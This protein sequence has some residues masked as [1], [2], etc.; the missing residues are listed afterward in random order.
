VNE[1]MRE[2]KWLISDDEIGTA[3]KCIS[4]MPTIAAI[5]FWLEWVEE[6]VAGGLD[7]TGLFGQVASGLA[8]LV[9]HAQLDSFADVTRN[10]GYLYLGG[11]DAQ[12]MEIHGQYP[13]SAVADQ[14][15]DRLYAIEAAESPPK[16]MS[17]VIRHLGL[18]PRAPLEERHTIQ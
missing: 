9:R 14:Y 1:L 18:G 3:V 6:L 10:F 4:G 12:S 13:K 2:V 11:D 17:D 16:L 15:A 8:F 7:D 5:E